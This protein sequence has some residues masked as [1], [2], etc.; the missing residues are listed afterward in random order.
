MQAPEPNVQLER[1]KTKS[2]S[3]LSKIIQAARTECPVRKD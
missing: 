2:Q 1:I 3:N